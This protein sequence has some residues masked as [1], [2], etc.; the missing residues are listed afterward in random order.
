VADNGNII[1]DGLYIIA[2]A[3]T[4]IKA[5][6]KEYIMAIIGPITSSGGVSSYNDL[7][8]VPTEFSP[9]DHTHV[10]ADISDYSA[11][12]ETDPVFTAWD[13]TTGISITESQISDLG[14]YIED[15]PSNGS[16]YARKDGAW[17]TFALAAATLIPTMPSITITWT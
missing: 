16:I 15:A 4:N 5:K 13:K 6:A 9:A 2:K 1:L 17:T 12:S 8:D 14:N 7:T 11:A 10:I 3:S